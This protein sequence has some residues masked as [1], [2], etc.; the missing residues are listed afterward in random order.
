MLLSFF[1]LLLCKATD[2]DQDEHLYVSPTGNSRSR[3]F[4]G[5]I[6]SPC[7]GIRELLN[8]TGH[9]QVVGGIQVLNLTSLQTNASHHYI[10][11]LSGIYI[12]DPVIMYGFSNWTFAGRGQVAIKIDSFYG[13]Y[14]S[15]WPY[16]SA[17]ELESATRR[18]PAAFYFRNCSNIE[19][20]NIEFYVDH[21]MAYD[22]AALTIDLSS[23]V[24]VNNCSFQEVSYDSSAVVI[25]YP[26]GPV[27]V[28]NCTVEGLHGVH[29]Y[30]ELFLVVFGDTNIEDFGVVLLENVIVSDIVAADYKPVH[31]QQLF[32]GTVKYPEYDYRSNWKAA[33]AILVLFRPGSKFHNFK[34]INCQIVRI[35]STD[36]H[37][38]ITIQ[39]QGAY[40]NFV[41]I[42]DCI[43]SENTGSVGGSVAI[44]FGGAI[45]K[46]ELTRNKVA[47]ER[48]N[49]TGNSALFNGGAVS[50]DYLTDGAY[51]QVIFNGCQFQGN[52][53]GFGGAL[54]LR[55]DP[56]NANGRKSQNRQVISIID[57]EFSSN[58]ATGGILMADG[59]TLSLTN[60]K[61]C[62]YLKYID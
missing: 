13:N 12:T 53:A 46:V 40:V 52:Q 18:Y 16:I 5:A 3:E 21:R 61:Y 30:R 8:R 34:M 58:K 37:S 2:A 44:F 25:L 15:L 50:V 1:L 36:N 28:Y 7:V 43:F 56:Y 31:L 17:V 39:F 20:T 54:I 48:C 14:P 6:D 57:C 26:I 45:S 11:F 23:T 60:T 41:T 19:I 51:N 4:C 38:P 32:E 9:L 24:F 22:I 62:A 10:H 33:T 59:V 29:G 27:I 55:Y 49:F 35:Q 47:F 42:S